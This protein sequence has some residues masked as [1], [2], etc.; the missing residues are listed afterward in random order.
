MALFTALSV[1]RGG[2]D[3]HHKYTTCGGRK[4]DARH[5]HSHHDHD[6]EEKYTGHNRRKDCKRK[7]H[8]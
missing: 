5:R 2:G 8:H 3:H 1:H 6:H 4:K 7:D